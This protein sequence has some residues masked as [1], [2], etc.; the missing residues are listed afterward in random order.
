MI[1]I[2]VMMGEDA[3]IMPACPYAVLTEVW[4]IDTT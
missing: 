2:N 3:G 4:R 1:N